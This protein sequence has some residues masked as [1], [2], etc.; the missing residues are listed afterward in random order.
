MKQ[1]KQQKI[2]TERYRLETN[3]KINKTKI[4]PNNRHEQINSLSEVDIHKIL[5]PKCL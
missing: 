5:K 2:N 3:T 4:M 1:N